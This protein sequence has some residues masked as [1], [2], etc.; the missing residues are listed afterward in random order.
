MSNIRSDFSNYL[1]S[2]FVE[3]I[4]F[5]R[6]KLFYFLGKIE[7]WD[8]EESTPSSPD[9][10]F[11]SDKVIRDNM[12][13]LRKI[14]PNDI[15]LVSN[16][17]D[18][19]SGKIFEQWD[20]TKDL[21]NSEF[22]CMTDEYNVY[23]CLSNNYNTAS[24]VK[25]TSTS[26]TAFKTN[27]GYIWKY[28]YNIPPFK[29]SKFLSN[30]YLPVQTALTDS[31]YN[32]GGI[33]RTVV[34]TGGS[35][36]TDEP[37]TSVEISSF[38]TTGSGAEVIITSVSGTGEIIAEGLS[39]VTGGTGYTSGAIVTVNSNTGTGAVL[40]ITETG[41]V[42]DGFNIIS[43]GTLYLDTDTI[44]ISV[45]GANLIPVI[46]DSTG[47]LLNVIVENPG[48]GYT[49]MTLS[50]T[51]LFPTGLETG[52]YGN[53]NAIITPILYQ[54]SIVEVLIEDPG[55]NYDVDTSTSIAVTGDGTDAK[56][57]PVIY[58]G[59][60]IDVIVENPGKN[61]SYINLDVVGNGTGATVEAVLKTS[62]FSSDQSLIEQTSVDGA[63]Y[64]IAIT[65]SGN[66]YSEDT[67]V[68]IVGDGIGA[69][70]SVVIENTS[71]SKIVMNTYGS[72][73]TY[74]NV[75][76]TDPNRIEPNNFTDA[77]TYAILSPIGG[78]GKNAVKELFGNIISLFTLII[79]DDELSLLE[80]DYRQY[81]FIRN[82]KIITTNNI[83]NTQTNFITYTVIFQNVV[84]LAVDELLINNNTN[85]RVVKIGTTE[86]ENHVVLQKLSNSS[87]IP[88]GSFLKEDGITS[89]NISSVFQSPTVNKYSGDLLYIKNTA[90]FVPYID[91][92][93]ALRTY[94]TI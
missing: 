20:H 84:D 32:S 21:T 17:Y 48:A 2:S 14:N 51:P 81:G 72:G 88:S 57:S 33:E 94:I 19:E 67:T 4:Y 41:G 47:E 6:S 40:E 26:L 49:A 11:I 83:L 54:G 9:L 75:I 53:P 50:L 7:Q 74:A 60:L 12:I 22:Y 43:P 44:T 66:N 28:M 82:P 78:H 79:D 39:I 55:L 76:I 61:Y 80:Q 85:Y 87:S 10:S 34:I 27:D 92:S 35:G 73:Y 56:F 3:D 58:N 64:S 71:I 65:E 91:K 8:A 1:S 31:F 86:S 52:K 16:R 42:I 59:E 25:P 37:Q 23:K 5:Q 46:S 45:G 77:I 90:P 29:R 93:I 38:T 69:T 89:Y 62:D 63:I 36:Y 24:T 30:N 13:Y 18:W 68:T 70:A 15:S